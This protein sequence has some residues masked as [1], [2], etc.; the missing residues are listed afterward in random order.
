[1]CGAGGHYWEERKELA[2]GCSPRS[3]GRRLFP[4]LPDPWRRQAEPLGPLMCDRPTRHTGCHQHRNSAD[5]HSMCLLKSPCHLTTTL[6]P[7]SLRT[8]TVNWFP[9]DARR[10]CKQSIY[11]KLFF[12]F[13]RSQP[14]PYPS[15]PVRA[16]RLLR[17]IFRDRV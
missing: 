12:S 5:C 7:N 15:F 11:C 3:L 14:C 4:L 1:M 6:S 2:S 8:F 17:P 10:H 13:D 16:G 9:P